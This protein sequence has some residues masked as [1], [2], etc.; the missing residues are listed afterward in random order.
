MRYDL[1]RL[2]YTRTN[3]AGN[4]SLG[5]LQNQEQT[6]RSWTLEDQPQPKKIRGETRIPAGFFTLGLRQELTPLT[7]K[8]RAAYNKPRPDGSRSWFQDN[9]EWF[10]IEVL[11]VPGFGSIY[12]HAGVD[13]SHTD[14]CLLPAY[15]IDLTKADR[16]TSSSLLAVEDFYRITYP[17]L[18]TGGLVHLAVHD[19]IKFAAA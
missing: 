5:F 7:E 18:I 15:V 2:F 13:D 19:E 1:Q 6:F 8:N 14:G 4:Y 12:V 3:A 10:H 16:P 11:N 17:V 9:P